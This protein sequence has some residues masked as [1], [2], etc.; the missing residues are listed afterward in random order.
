[1]NERRHQALG[2]KRAVSDPERAG[3]YRLEI[4]WADG[5]TGRYPWGYLRALCPCAQCRGEVSAR[6][7]AAPADA[8]DAPVN[9]AASLQNVGHYALGVVWEDGHQSILPWDF[10]RELDPQEKSLE[11]R[12]AF[13]RADRRMQ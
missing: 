12:L 13:V 10:L 3:R 2:A 9:R 11:E 5:H 7:A 4:A 1:M 6:L 8:A